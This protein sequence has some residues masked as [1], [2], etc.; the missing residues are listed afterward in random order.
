MT[1]LVK[2][3]RDERNL[4]P[5]HPPQ[6]HDFVVTGDDFIQASALR[7]LVDGLEL[8]RKMS[9]V[10]TRSSSDVEALFV[11]LLS[12]NIPGKIENNKKKTF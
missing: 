7:R 10:A 8:I 6:H 3:T 9:A 12:K 2:N 11:E 1:L 4:R 5:V